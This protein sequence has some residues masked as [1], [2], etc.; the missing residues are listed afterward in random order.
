MSQGTNV[1]VYT[2]F[3]PETVLLPASKEQFPYK[4]VKDT[5]GKGN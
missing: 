5:Y 2:E 4:S 1:D 3:K